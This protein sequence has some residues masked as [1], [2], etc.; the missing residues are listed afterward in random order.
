MRSTERRRRPRRMVLPGLLLAALALGWL[1]NDCVGLGPGGGQATDL[2]QA[3]PEDQRP[4]DAGAQAGTDA[5]PEP[6]ALRLDSA[7][8]TLDSA[9]ATIEQAARACAAA[10]KARLEATGAA[11]AGTY[12]E[13]MRALD[14]AGVH[15]DVHMQRPAAPARAGDD[16]SVPR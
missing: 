14:R 7:G 2:A 3:P 6:C 9:P 4:R 1:L 13:L 11:R 16:A 8:L 12:D 10:G 5:R 15:V